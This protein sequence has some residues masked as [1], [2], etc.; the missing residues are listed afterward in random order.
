MKLKTEKKQCNDDGNRLKKFPSIVHHRPAIN[1]IPE[2]RT[3]RSE[4]DFSAAKGPGDKRT[5][6]K[7]FCNLLHFPSKIGI[8]EV[9]A[10][11]FRMNLSKN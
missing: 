4:R 5:D 9:D 6:T 7:M 3:I 11:G 1:P 10:P 8:S 2:I